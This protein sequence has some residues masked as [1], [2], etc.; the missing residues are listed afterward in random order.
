MSKKED[1]ELKPVLKLSE[2]ESKEVLKSWEYA[3]RMATA[4]KV[5]GQA[6]R[7]IKGYLRDYN[8]RTVIKFKENPLKML[9]EVDVTPPEEK[10]EKIEEEMR[11]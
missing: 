4:I 5:L 9:I 3:S 6:E 11:V 2:K 10:E 1:E 8:I 7:Y